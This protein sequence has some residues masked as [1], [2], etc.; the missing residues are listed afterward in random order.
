MGNILFFVQLSIFVFILFFIYGKKLDFGKK[1]YLCTQMETNGD[2][3]NA[4]SESAVNGTDDREAHP[5]HWVAVLVQVRSEKAVGDKLNAL[6]IESYVPTQWEMHQWSDRKKKVERVVIPMV[7]FVHV[8]KALE[9]CLRTYSFI[10]KVLSYP[11][12]NT[13]A[14]IPDEQINRLKFML[15]HA[16][17]PVEM[18]DRILQVGETVRVIRGPLKDLT[19]ELSQVDSGRPMVAIRIECLGYACVSISKSDIEIV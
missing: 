11:G 3:L 7:V 5:K 14:V 9:K 15:R 4:F 12:Q 18:K 10:Y 1:S 16:D 19:G 8:D 2:T 13:A 6:G 17:S